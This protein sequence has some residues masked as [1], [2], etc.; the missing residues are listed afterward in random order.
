[1]ERIYQENV[2]SALQ[3]IVSC[4]PTLKK[5]DDCVDLFN[6][7]SNNKDSID[8]P[9]YEANGMFVGSGYIESLNKSFVHRRLKE[10]GMRWYV[11]S[12]NYILTLRRM[13]FNQKWNEFEETIRDYYAWDNQIFIV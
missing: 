9:T 5:P 2:P 10:P 13:A 11:N 3:Y 4:N 12:A 8:Y 1:M 7:I 6:Y